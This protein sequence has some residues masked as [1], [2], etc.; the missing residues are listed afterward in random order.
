MSARILISGL[1]AVLAGTA[2]TVCAASDPCAACETCNSL[3]P[4]F[5]RAL[6]QVADST[7]GDVVQLVRTLPHPPHCH[8]LSASSRIAHARY[9]R[10]KGSFQGRAQCSLY[11]LLSN[12]V[13][14]LP[15]FWTKAKYGKMSIEGRDPV[16][17]ET[18]HYSEAGAVDDRKI[19]VTPR[20]ANIPGNLQVRQS[21][22]FD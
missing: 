22:R 21:D 9:F 12:D 18:P 1:L 13:E 20:N 14:G 3:I 4:L 5:L 7:V 11:Q 8:G 15:A 16:N 10:R 2:A 6:R 19:L 17:T